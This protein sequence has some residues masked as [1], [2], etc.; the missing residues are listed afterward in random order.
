MITN[1]IHADN[2]MMNWFLFRLRIQKWNVRIVKKK[3]P[4]V[5]YPHQAF[6]Q[7]EVPIIAAIPA[8]HHQGSHELTEPVVTG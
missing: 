6:L 7:R 1:A 5:C 4:N 8:T 3:I 2:S